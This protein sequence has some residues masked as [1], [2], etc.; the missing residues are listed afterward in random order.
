MARSHSRGS[1]GEGRGMREKKRWGLK[2]KRSAEV[3]RKIVLKTKGGDKEE[4]ERRGRI[5]K[6]L[7]I[8]L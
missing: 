3:S 4:G 1:Y 6:H 7:I 2:M 8:N 5:S